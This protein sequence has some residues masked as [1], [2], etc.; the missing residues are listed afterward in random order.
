M[1]PGSELIPRAESEVAT[2]QGRVAAGRRPTA[3]G[4]L[5]KLPPRLA[6]EQRTEGTEGARVADGT[7][8]HTWAWA[9]VGRGGTGNGG[10][11]SGLPR[12]GGVC[13]RAGRHGEA[14]GRWRAGRHGCHRAGGRAEA[15]GPREGSQVARRFLRASG[16]PDRPDAPR[17]P[18]VTLARYPTCGRCRTPWCTPA[19]LGAVGA[20]RCLGASLE[21]R[22]GTRRRA[23]GLRTCWV[24]AEGPNDRGGGGVQRSR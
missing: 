8:K 7:E 24:R 14:G 19:P 21:P 4:W 11:V 23:G 3:G 16:G 6:R 20:P 2:P 5:P 22:E 1:G 17:I 10:G 15:Q 12:G 9:G 13:G 18:L